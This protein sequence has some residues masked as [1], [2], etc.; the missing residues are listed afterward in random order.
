M[1]IIDFG[2]FMFFLVKI[3]GLKIFLDVCK[4]FSFFGYFNEK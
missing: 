1:N 2:W 4:G 3:V